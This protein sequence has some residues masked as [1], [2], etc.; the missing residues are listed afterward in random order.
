MSHAIITRALQYTPDIEFENSEALREFVITI[1][2]ETDATNQ[3]T[4]QV[5]HQVQHQVEHQVEHQVQHQ[6]K[7]QLTQ[8]QRDIV[9]FC[10]VPRTAQEIMDRIGVYNQ[11]RSRKRYIQPLIDAGVLEMTDPETPNAPNQKYRKVRK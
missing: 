1:Q 11:T 6:P 2:R 3:I 5:K 8:Q 10:S 9:N 4:N 7:A